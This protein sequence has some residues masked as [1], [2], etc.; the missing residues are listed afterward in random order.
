MTMKQQLN[1]SGPMLKFVLL[2]GMAL[3]LTGCLSTKEPVFDETNSL[4]V[5]EIPEFIAFVDAWESF[6]GADDS[7]REMTAQGGRGII[8]DGILVVQD[9][10]EY[11]AVAVVA[12]RPLACVIHADEAI[13]A[14]AAKHGVT[15]ELD[16]PEPGDLN[17]IGPVPVRA[18]GSPEALMAFIR[19]Q[20]TNQALACSMQ[21]RGG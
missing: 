20:F 2:A 1:R 6:V 8:V 10:A 12:G 14:V 13:Q 19:D 15:V 18:D 3:L 7:P 17:S 11:F 16:N 5:G 9:K 21:R 4:P